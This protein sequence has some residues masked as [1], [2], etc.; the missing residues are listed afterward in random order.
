MAHRQ[1]SDSGF[2]TEN[3]WLTPEVGATGKPPVRN[4]PILFIFRL[5]CDSGQIM[6]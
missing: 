6:W 4:A 5:R 2:W 3:S 1:D